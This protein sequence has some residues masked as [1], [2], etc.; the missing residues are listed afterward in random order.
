MLAL[1]KWLADPTDSVAL[2]VP[3]ALAASVVSAL[4]DCA[5]YF[6]LILNFGMH[7]LVAA[8]GGYL[9]GGVMQYVLCSLWVFPNA[10]ANPATGFLIFTALSMVGLAITCLSM[11]ILMDVAHIHYG[12]AK[13][14]SLGFAFGWN[15][16][17]RKLLF[18][19][20]SAA[21]A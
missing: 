10:P 15:F 8:V 18:V 1:K 7:P 12:L 5:F 13:V 3:R 16:S 6:A 11:A 9:V 2:Q 19:R 4:V 14:L 20:A 17:S 21:R